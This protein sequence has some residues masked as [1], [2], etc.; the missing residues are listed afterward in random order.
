MNSEKR[1][2]ILVV[3]DERDNLDA[4]LK[5]FGEEYDL[6]P[7]ASGKEALKIMEEQNSIGVVVADQRMDEMTGVELLEEVKKRSPDVVRIV[8]TGYSD[9]QVPIDAINRGDVFRYL[10]K[11]VDMDLTKRSLDE[12]LEKYKENLE[13][14]NRLGEI[15]KK[16]QERFLQIH[17]SLAAGVAHHVNNGL[18]PA[19]T[20][21]T[22]FKEKAKDLKEGKVDAAYFEEF[23]EEALTNIG[24]VENLTKMLLWADN[25]KV[26]AFVE[27]RMEDLIDLNREDLK[28]IFQKKEISADVQIAPNLPP[29]VVD[30]EKVREMFSLIIKNCAGAAPDKSKIHIQAKDIRQHEGL[31]LV[32]TE[33]SYEGRG[34]T[35]EEI[36]R[37]FDP[38]YKFDEKLGTSVSGLELTNCFVIAIKHGCEL[39]VESEPQKKTTFIVELPTLSKVPS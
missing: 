32:R 31:H 1:Y 10:Q 22:L 5:V 4:F 18:V 3:D 30:P 13:S 23:L 9:F 24:K 27:A 35:A 17:E 21:L 25:C 11:P 14:K 6:V 33:I 34:Y 36:P 29:M 26:E 28:E 38:F 16:I 2:K 15:K 8:L 19:K 20:F 7:A 37:L 12:A 39:K